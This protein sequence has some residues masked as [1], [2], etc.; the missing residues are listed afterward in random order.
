[1]LARMQQQSKRINN[2]TDWVLFQKARRLTLD[3]S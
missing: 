1:M 2:V 3:P